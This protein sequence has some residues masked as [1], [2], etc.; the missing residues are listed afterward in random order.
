MAIEPVEPIYASEDLHQ[1]LQKLMD[2]GFDKLPIL[3]QTAAEEE[4]I[5]YLTSPDLL[6]LYHEEVERRGRDE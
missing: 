1:A 3:H 6:R 5:G 2:S 4:L